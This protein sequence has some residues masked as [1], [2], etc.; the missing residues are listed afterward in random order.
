ML[1]SATWIL[2]LHFNLITECYH[3]KIQSWVVTKFYVDTL[4]V[5]LCRR[6]IVKTNELCLLTCYLLNIHVDGNCVATLWLLKRLPLNILQGK[7]WKPYFIW[8]K[9][10]FMDGEKREDTGMTC[11]IMC[12]IQKIILC[13]NFISGS[14]GKEFPFSRAIAYQLLIYQ[15]SNAYNTNPRRDVDPDLITNLYAECLDLWT[16]GKGLSLSN[17]ISL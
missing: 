6:P 4:F 8:C 16:K 1:G 7:E 17:L 11:V 12:I 15:R 3:L 2:F 9:Q 10:I 5:Y 13:K 14:C